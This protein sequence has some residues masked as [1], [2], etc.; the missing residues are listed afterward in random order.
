MKQITIKLNDGAEV[1][2]QVSESDFTKL[3]KVTTVFSSRARTGY[4]RV[5]PKKH[6]Y[7]STRDYYCS[8]EREEMGTGLDADLFNKGDYINDEKLYNDR[9]RA[10]VLHDR[11]EQWQALN[12]ES[13]DWDDTTVSK[14]RICFDYWDYQIDCVATIYSR[15]EGVIYFST[16][17]KAQEALEVFRDDLMWYYTEYRSRLDE[18]ERKE[19]K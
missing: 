10:R 7:A 2:A 6:Y 5:K 13:V 16:S 15:E 19:D 14:Y 9:E 18:P 1:V 4:E 3:N 12:D 17:Q 11:L 8:A